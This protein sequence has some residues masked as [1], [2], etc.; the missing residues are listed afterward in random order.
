MS[1]ELLSQDE[2]DALLDGVGSGEV[3][4][5][6]DEPVDGVRPFSF[7]AQD[8]IVRGR[9]PSLEMVA[10]RFARQFR[11]TLF[12]ILRRN[13]ELN[14]AGLETLKYSDYMHRLFVPTNLNLM[15]VKPLRGTALLVFE[16]KL[17][18]SVVDRFFGGDGS[19]HAR[20]EGREFTPTE[21][22]VI[23]ILV[24]AAFEDLVEAWRP[25]LPLEF[26]YIQSELN[27]HLATIVSPS[28]IVVV[29]RFT[30]DLDG[31]GGDIHLTMPYS[32]LEP[33]R[34]QLSHGIQ[35]D[36]TDRDES[37]ISNMRSHVADA[38]VELRGVLAQPQLTLADLL[39]LTD[40]DV[41][42]IQWP[43]K[44]ELRVEGVTRFIGDFGTANGHNAVRIREVV[45]NEPP[46][47]NPLGE[48]DV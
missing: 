5:E 46:N 47:A 45:T 31:S 24:D 23:R 18:F 13:P 14:F 7:G 1:E 16:P 9:L 28:E 6:D 25:V 43:P 4:T 10:E 44:L 29:A 42:P 41:I 22:R 38:R 19:F 3:E 35:S 48:S 34:D 8:R 30:V 27:P 12:N 40:E 36:R 33:I 15:R 39:S 2:I 26:E 17:V 37:W 21:M 32:M 20:I 11:I